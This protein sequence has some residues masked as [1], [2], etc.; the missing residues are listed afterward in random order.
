MPYNPMTS[1]PVSPGNY[2]QPWG[3]FTPAPVTGVGVRPDSRH[4]SRKSLDTERQRANWG[5]QGSPLGGTSADIIRAAP[6]GNPM[7]VSAKQWKEQPDYRKPVGR[8]EAPI[9]KLNPMGM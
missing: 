4:Y 7:S 9:T 6:N 1:G 3:Y 8:A 5:T 2:V